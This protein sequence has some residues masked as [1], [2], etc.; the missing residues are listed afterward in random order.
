MEAK[1][2]G[3]MCDDLEFRD[4]DLEVVSRFSDRVGSC[5]LIMLFGCSVG[6]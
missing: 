5:S 2:E 1:V 4:Y 6:V 3:V